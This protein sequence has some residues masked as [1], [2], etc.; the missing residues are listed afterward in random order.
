[1]PLEPLATNFG[2]HLFA[3]YKKT[4]GKQRQRVD[5]DVKESTKNQTPF[6]VVLRAIVGG[7]YKC[8]SSLKTIFVWRLD[9]YFIFFLQV[10]KF[11]PRSCVL[12]QQ[13][14]GAQI[15][16]YWNQSTH[17]FVFWR[18]RTR[19]GVYKKINNPSQARSHLRPCALLPAV[20]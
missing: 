14:K 18:V 19:Y 13:Q 16:K 8:L 10:P 12:G 1:M 4:P 6:P 9:N 2:R 11:Y 3:C 5:T 15:I 20:V 17:V 7:I